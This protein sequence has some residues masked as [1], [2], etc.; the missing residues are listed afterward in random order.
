MAIRNLIPFGRQQGITAPNLWRESE[1]SPLTSFRRE[2][3]RL[4]NDLTSVPATTRFGEFSDLS[5]NWPSIDVKDKENEL[6][7]TAEV[8][9]LTYKDVD[10]FVDNRML[11]NI[12]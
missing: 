12:C 1:F 6:L 7:V 9:G 11:N 8:P 3:D 2:M 5:A 4:F 10:L